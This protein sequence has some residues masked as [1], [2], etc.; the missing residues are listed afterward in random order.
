[1]CVVCVMICDDPLHGAMDAARSAMLTAA[2]TVGAAEKNKAGELE[3][4]LKEI[5]AK[6][7]KVEKEKEDDARKK[8]RLTERAKGLSDADLVS[9]LVLFFS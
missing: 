2:A 3:T 9:M 7:K 4:K 6:R 5:A 1:M 8:A